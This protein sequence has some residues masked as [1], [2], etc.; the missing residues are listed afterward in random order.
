MKIISIKKI[1]CELI[2]TDE[3]G[4][5]IYRRIDNDNW[6]CLMNDSWESVYDKELEEEYQ[7]IRGKHD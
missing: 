4:H 3:T 6:E 5:N 7:K 2:E 1:I